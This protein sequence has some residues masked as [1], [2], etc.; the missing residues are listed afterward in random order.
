MSYHR[1]FTDSEIEQM[2]S[3]YLLGQQNKLGAIAKRRGVKPGCVLSAIK[4]HYKT[5]HP[6]D[7]PKQSRTRSLETAAQ[8]SLHRQAE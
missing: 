2:R 4:Y 3:E 6:D 7:K 5:K 8:G 1:N